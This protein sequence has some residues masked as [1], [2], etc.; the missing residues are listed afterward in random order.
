MYR[1]SLTALQTFER[2]ASLGSQ[3]AAADELGVTATAVSH[4]IRSLEERLAVRLFI[5]QGRNLGLTPEG[6]KLAARLRPAFSQIDRAVMDVRAEDRPVVISVTPAFAACWLAPRLAHHAHRGDP[7]QMRTDLLRIDATTR[8]VSDLEAE[9]ISL[10]VRY[11]RHT[12]EEHLTKERFYVVAASS[13]SPTDEIFASLPLLET[14]WA[15]GEGYAPN[16]RDWFAAGGKAF[17]GSPRTV[18]F[19]DE[20]L[21]IQSALAGTGIALVS[22]VLAS[23]LVKR[24]LLR[25]LQPEVS[26]EGMSY[27]LV[28]N[29]RLL[30]Y[31]PARNAADWLRREFA[32]QSR[33]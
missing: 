17:S 33:N 19:D 4:A 11:A 25:I 27:W 28:Q 7:A 8:P 9:N 10:A 23:D 6:E 30:G 31:R 16:W 13:I 21:L 14:R 26:V 20:Q 1:I 18:H 12:D 32:D 22:S 3:R 29:P 2:V 5:R 24:S 15:R